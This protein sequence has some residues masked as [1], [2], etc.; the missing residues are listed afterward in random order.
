V[1][2]VAGIVGIVLAMGVASLSPVGSALAQDLDA[3][4]ADIADDINAVKAQIASAQSQRTEVADSILDTDARLTALVEDLRA[5]E[6]DLDA[7]Q[8][9]VADRRETLDE[10]REDLQSQYQA[11]ELTRFDLQSTRQDA[12]S[13]ALQIYMGGGR[14]SLGTVLF[15]AEEMTTLGV[16]LE[17]A[18]QIA[19]ST[20]Q[21]VNRLETLEILSLRQAELIAE[22]EDALELEVVRLEEQGSL[23]EEL[24]DIVTERRDEVQRELDGQRALL[25]SVRSDIDLFEKELDG[26]EAEQARIEQ[27]IR[28]ESSSGGSA[29][30]GI[31]VR[32]VPGGITSGF[33]YRVHPILGTRRLHTGVDMSAGS[34]TPIRAAAAGRVILAAYYGGYG[35]AVIIDHGGGISTLYAHQSRIGVSKGTQVGAGDTIGFVGSTGFSTGPHLH[36]EVRQNG[37]PV[38]PSSYL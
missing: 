33:G 16:G 20:D 15:T 36:F 28:S 34:G 35:N 25:Q 22:R 3:D 12:R 4:L 5:T 9:E 23:L 18:S 38:N 14:G 2:R 26:L 30:S 1:R 6:A 31:F 8:T 13:R 10:T 7:L 17:Y 27:L 37:S 21:L 19:D 29:P 11:L 32:P 24:A